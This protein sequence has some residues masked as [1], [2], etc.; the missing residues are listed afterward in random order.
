MQSYVLRLFLSFM[1]VTACGS[2]GAQAQTKPASE[3]P[4]GEASPGSQKPPIDNIQL[5]LLIKSTIMALQHAN[6]TGNYSVLRDLGTPVFRERFDQAKLTAIFA[7]LRSRGVNLSPVLMIMPN[8]TKQPEL[9]PP[10]ALRVVGNFP[11]QPLQIQYEF[12]F[13][14]IDGVW[15]VEGLAVDA[16]PAQAVAD[17]TAASALA[18]QPPAAKPVASAEKKSKAKN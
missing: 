7:N 16:V 8:L 5:A 1:I 18:P 6:Q 2:T 14:L 13:L 11:T 17:A 12:L 10:N 4:S 3:K 15:R 9:T